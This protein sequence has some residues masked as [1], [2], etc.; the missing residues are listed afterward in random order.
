MKKNKLKNQNGA[1]AILTLMAVT[2]FS[3]LIMTTMNVLAA[4][5]LK[6]STSERNTEKTF[7]AAETGI[8]AGLYKLVS[9]PQPQEF[10]LSFDG[11]SINCS[12]AEKIK[13][14]ISLDPSNPYGRKISSEATDNT[15]KVRTQEI[16][17]LTS[18]YATTLNYAVHAG[19]GGLIIAGNGS[20]V[21]GDVFANGNIIPENQGYIGNILASDIDPIHF[22]G[23]VKVSGLGNRIEQMNIVGNAQASLL[24]G[25]NS[26]ELTIG[27]VS[28]G[29]FSEASYQ[30]I[31][32]DNYVL[33]SGLTCVTSSSNAYC[34]NNTPPPPAESLP[35]TD[36]DITIWTNDIT[37]AVVNAIADGTGQSLGPTNVSGNPIWGPTK[38]N[39]HLTFTNNASLTIN[40][41]L[42]V[43]GDI[44]LSNNS[45]ITLTANV[46]IEGNLNIDNGTRFQLAAS[47]GENDG[48]VIVNNKITVANGVTVNGSGNAK[49]SLSLI[50]KHISTNPT[51]PSIFA[52][53]TSTGVIYY[54][55]H[56]LVRVS[57]TGDLSAVIANTIYLENNAT[58][59]FRPQLQ[60]FSVPDPEPE[61]IFTIS[62]SWQEK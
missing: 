59:R 45:S 22:P 20:R 28:H 35:I 30:T 19:S 49:S 16:S 34:H 21:F 17:V 38:I 58:V 9:S 48:V 54:T 2:V 41:P 50:T 18:T 5:E 31:D 3:L 42:W 23:N 37:N 12:Q 40:G 4:D 52:S 14:T 57:Q 6:M 15:G 10:C 32:N 62:Q 55:N 61:P 26:K 13:I 51:D 24:K 29:I 8:N 36:A 39:G 44:T 47:L 7:Y 1:I 46:F 53:N 25:S 11:Q 43:T 56:G 33:A 60:F 27:D